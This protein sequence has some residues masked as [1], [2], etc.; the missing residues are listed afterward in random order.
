M[1]HHNSP[2]TA[3]QTKLIGTM[4]DSALA[5]RLGRTRRAVSS[6]RDSLGIAAFT[7][8]RR[9][10]TPA[11]LKLLGTMPDSAVAKKLGCGRLHVTLTRLRLGVECFAPQMRPRK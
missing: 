4:T 9:Q 8:H 3:A 6:K 5:K 11:E 10:W 2:W 1:N 7:P